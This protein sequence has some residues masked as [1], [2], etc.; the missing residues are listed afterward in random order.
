MRILLLA[1]MA[2]SAPAHADPAPLILHTELGDWATTVDELRKNGGRTI[3]VEARDEKG[4]VRCGDYRL[5]LD[6]AG[7]RAFVVGKCDPVTQTIELR[8]IDRH[9]LFTRV[10]NLAQ[11]ILPTL[12]ASRPPAPPPPFVSETCWAVIGP[13]VIDPESGERKTIAPERLALTV[14]PSS[15]RAQAIA[16]DHAWLVRV[17]KSA[18]MD[19]VRY[20]LVPWHSESASKSGLRMELETPP[21]IVSTPL[22]LRCEGDPLGPWATRAVPNRLETIDVNGAPITLRRRQSDAGLVTQAIFGPSLLVVGGVGTLLVGIPLTAAGDGPYHHWHERD[23]GIGVL[24]ASTALVAVGGYLTYSELRRRAL[25]RGTET[26]SPRLAF[27]PE[28]ASLSF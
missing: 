3:H 7:S 25:R 8:L 2:S 22:P 27:H 15:A 18:G 10:E 26:I 11:P 28:S 14:E 17:P 5:A 24:A 12:T 4:P 1:L 21:G 9:F 20:A 16:F 19:R 13:T 6:E 23:V